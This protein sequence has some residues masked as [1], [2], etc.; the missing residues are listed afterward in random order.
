MKNI[1]KYLSANRILIIGMLTILSIS[2][3]KDYNGNFE[4]PRQ[5]KPGDINIT[6]GETQVKLEWNASLFTTGKDVQYTVEVSK[7]GTFQGAI[8][9][10]QTIDTSVIVI[11]DADLEV[12]QPYYA[13]VKANALGNTEESGWVVSDVFM[14][15]GEQI[16]FPVLD[17]ELKDTSVIL[18]WRPTPGLTKI[19]VTPSGGASFDIPLDATD[20]ANNYKFIDVLAPLTNYTAEIF[21]GAVSKGTVDF[22]TKEPNIFTIILNPGDDLVTAVNNAVTGDI[23]GLNPGTY[24]CLDGTGTFT[25]LVILQKTI[26]IQS[27]SGDPLDTRVNFKEINLKG[28]GAGVT[29][30]GIDFDASASTA[31]GQTALYFLNF[32]GLAADGD[33]AVFTDVL[34]ENCR[35][36]E[37]GNTFMRANRGSSNGA[38][39]INSIKINNSF[40]YNLATVNTNYSFFQINKLAFATLEVTNSTLYSIGRCFVDWDATFS[41]NPRPVITVDHCT[42]NNLG[43]A[44]QTYILFDVNANDV[45]VTMSNCIFGNTPYPGA[46]V[47]PGDLI[48]AGNAIIGINNSNLFNIMDGAMP[49][50]APLTIPS[51]VT[52]NNITNIDLGWTG[53]TTDFTLPQGSPLRT[54]STTGGPIGDPRWAF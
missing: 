10:T 27:V 24:D 7:D 28:N 33:P 43:L 38:H 17:I 47:G 21:K 8:D 37:M 12:R 34:V 13:R 18:R 11:T 5:F 40:V 9:Y 42:I 1:F 30:K 4:L 25:T 22:T 36:H 15:T 48:R 3:K 39:K 32:T 35:V 44:N 29:L 31:T 53:A 52:L 16:F 49:T 51:N 26:G 45:E 46:T 41:V 23:I 20:I 50:S 6:Q 19:T 2:C 54:A 14:I